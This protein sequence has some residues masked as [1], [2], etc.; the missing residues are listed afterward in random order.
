MDGVVVAVIATVAVCLVVAVVILEAPIEHVVVTE[1][2]FATSTTD[3]VGPGAKLTELALDKSVIRG[4]ERGGAGREEG[5][6]VSGAVTVKTGL[7]TAEERDVTENDGAEE[8]R[9]VETD[10]DDA[11]ITVDEETLE[12]EAVNKSDNEQGKVV[13][14]ETGSE[15]GGCTE[16]ATMGRADDAGL[17]TDGGALPTKTVPAFFFLAGAFF[18]LL[19]FSHCFMVSESILITVVVC[20]VVGVVVVVVG[21]VW[22]AY[23]DDTVVA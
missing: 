14:D 6:G 8:E 4:A 20:V 11:T 10:G 16:D 15:A 2:E 21:D 13:S 17:G 1:R 5:G 23:E 12:T 22:A 7:A 9:V 18:F 3:E 19:L